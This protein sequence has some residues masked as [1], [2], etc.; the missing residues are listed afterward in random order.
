MKQKLIKL[1]YF[2]IGLTIGGLVIY[3]QFFDIAQSLF[4]D[5]RWGK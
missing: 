2:S 1:I 4:Y 5:V 3:Y